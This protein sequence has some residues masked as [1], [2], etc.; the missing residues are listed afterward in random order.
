MDIDA[1]AAR[2]AK[3]LTRP[4]LRAF[5]P[6]DGDPLTVYLRA[7]LDKAGLLGPPGCGNA[8]LSRL[9]R[10]TVSQVWAGVCLTAE[11]RLVYD[12]LN[13]GGRVWTAAEGME[14]GPWQGEAA[15]RLDDLTENGLTICP[16]GE[17]IRWMP[18][19]V[20]ARGLVTARWLADAASRGVSRVMLTRRA[21]VTPLAYD[22][23]AAGHILMRRG[24]TCDPGSGGRFG[25]GH[26]EM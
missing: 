18:A 2:L 12:T 10:E 13:A 7:L 17:L 8:V 6:K 9:S 19:G 3:E 15:R 21:V 26:P 23:A 16:A 11:S 20:T 5:L 1:L 4:P 22:L 25:V 24:W 14:S